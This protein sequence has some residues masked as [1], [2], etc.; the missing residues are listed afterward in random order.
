MKTIEVAAQWYGEEASVPG[1]IEYLEFETPYREAYDE[2]VITADT[3]ADFQSAYFSRVAASADGLWSRRVA[4]VTDALI[5]G[6][7]C[8]V[9]L[10]RVSAYL[11]GHGVN[12]S[13]Q[14][15]EAAVRENR[16]ESPDAFDVR[17]EAI[18][19]H[20]PGIHVYGHWIIDYVSRLLSI[21]LVEQKTGV[22]RP[23]LIKNMPGWA[24]AFIEAAGLADRVVRYDKSHYVMV[25]SLWVPV[26]GKNGL[27][28]CTRQMR[29]SFDFLRDCYA[30]DSPRDRRLPHRLVLL[31]R[32]TPRVTDQE[33]LEA[34]FTRRGFV[35]FY[36]ED[37]SLADQIA[38]F[39]AAEWIAGEDGSAL[40][41]IGFCRPGARVL[42]WSRGP[43]N[44]FWH[45]S[46]AMAAQARITYLRTSGTDQDYRFDLDENAAAIE[47]FLATAVAD[48]AVVPQHA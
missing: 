21:R 22:R 36:P 33:T 32:K 30:K 19:L 15:L 45:A 44:N 48:R 42:I 37:H 35:A 1:P 18:L 16:L 26:I 46:V 17:D 38:Y 43:R 24:F 8:V 20:G 11:N 12:W 5:F 4:R 41:N 2:R 47:T 28:L 9:Y 39:E 27:T 14:R 13:R 23:I 3:D 10:P 7:A 31:R 29:E 40:H 34:Y 6:Q 25:K